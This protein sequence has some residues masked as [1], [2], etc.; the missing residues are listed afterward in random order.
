MTMGLFS[1]EK[2]AAIQCPQ[3]NRTEDA[4]AFQKIMCYEL[5]L[6]YKQ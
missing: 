3:A 4:T 5:D 6:F 2:V 1:D